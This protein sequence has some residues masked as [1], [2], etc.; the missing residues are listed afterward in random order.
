MQ[1]EICEILKNEINGLSLVWA[2][3][4]CGMVEQISEKVMTASG[5]ITKIY[6]AYR[7]PNQTG[8]SANQDYTRCLPE[9]SLR[10]LLYMEAGEP[11]RTATTYRYDEYTL[12][13]QVVIW[14]NLIFINPAYHNASFFADELVGELSAII[15]DSAPYNTIRLEFVGESRNLGVVSRY[16]MDEAESQMWLY[17]FDFTVVSVNIRFRKTRNCHENVAL[18]PSSCK[19]Y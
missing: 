15:G 13:I 3:R 12:P 14:V 7:N 11:S 1:R 8:C 6:P 17:P 2:D 18:N 5:T 16:S 9:T 4:V 10:S 19:V